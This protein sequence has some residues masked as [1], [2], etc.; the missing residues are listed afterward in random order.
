MASNLQAPSDVSWALKQEDKNK[1]KLSHSEDQVYGAPF[2]NDRT[3]DGC[4]H[5][6]SVKKRKIRGDNHEI[7]PRGVFLI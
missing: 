4:D 2:A 5:L 7:P 3:A 1:W 6:N